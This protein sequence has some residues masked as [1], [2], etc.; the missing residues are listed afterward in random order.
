MRITMTGET[1][2]GETMSGNWPKA[3]TMTLFLSRVVLS[4]AT[5]QSCYC[6]HGSIARDHGK[7]RFN[8][9]DRCCLRG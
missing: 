8:R 9:K 3:S 6:A 1:G 5:D 4:L 7:T 2:A